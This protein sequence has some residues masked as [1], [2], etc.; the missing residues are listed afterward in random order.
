ML[1]NFRALWGILLPHRVRPKKFLIQT[2]DDLASE[3]LGLAGIHSG[4]NSSQVFLK[5]FV[6]DSTYDTRALTRLLVP[7]GDPGRFG[8]DVCDDSIFN[9]GDLIIV[10]RVSRLDEQC[11]QSEH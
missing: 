11:C 4:L 6:G 5:T 10:E 8:T 7:A 1:R 3:I 9:L 2:A